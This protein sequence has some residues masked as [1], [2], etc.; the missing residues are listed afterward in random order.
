[1]AADFLEKSRYD[2]NSSH[3]KTAHAI[4]FSIKNSKSSLNLLQLK[5]AHH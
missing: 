3:I 5:A 4:A 1:M 2:K